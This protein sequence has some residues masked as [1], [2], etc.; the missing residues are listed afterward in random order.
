MK[1]ISRR[2]TK[3]LAVLPNVVVKNV[4]QLNPLAV[5]SMTVMWS[6][7]RFYFGEIL[8]VI[9]KGA[10]GRYGSLPSS[11]SISGLSFLSLRVYLPLTTVRSPYTLLK[12]GVNS[13]CRKGKT[14][15]KTM[16]RNL[17]ISLRHSFLAITK[18]LGFVSALTRKLSMSFSILD[19]VY[20]N[21]PRREYDTA[22]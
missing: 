19:L 4:H 6:G 10:N 9:K 13:N 2:F 18:I 5:G 20:S 11:P 17:P 22:R 3:G 16:I 12:S 15:T 8:D 1:I 21:E 14:T 7:T